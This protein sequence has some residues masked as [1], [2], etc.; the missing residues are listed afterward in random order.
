MDNVYQKKVSM[1]HHMIQIKIIIMIKPQLMVKIN[2]QEI[3][4]IQVSQFQ[5]NHVIILVMLVQD[6]IQQIVQ[7]VSKLKVE[8]YKMAFVDAHYHT[9]LKDKNNVVLVTILV[10]I[11][12]PEKQ[13]ENVQENVQNI[14]N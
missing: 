1:T 6:Q 4:L 2:N 12:V 10:K 8:Y 5:L 7:N 11:N 13:L 3:I 14:E 9:K